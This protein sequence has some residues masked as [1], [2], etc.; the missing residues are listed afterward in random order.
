[1]DANS[2][3]IDQGEQALR[4]R[5]DKNARR[6]E[7]DDPPQSAPPPIRFVITAEAAVIWD[8][9]PEHRIYG[10]FPMKGLALVYGEKKCGKSFWT[11][12]AVMHVA[13]NIPYRGHDVIGGVVVYIA[14]EGQAGLPKRMEAYRR[15]HKHTTSDFYLCTVKPDLMADAPELIENIKRQLGSRRPGIVVVD[16]LNRTL[17]GSESK[18]VD[19][20]RYLAAA[21]SIKDEFGCLVIVVHHCGLEKGR[22]RGH[23]ALSAA[24]DVQIVV[25]RDAAKNVVAEV[26]LAKDGASGEKFT[27]RLDQA[28][29][30]HDKRGNEMTT[31]VIVPIANEESEL[32]KPVKPELSVP[33]QL[34][35]RALANAISER[36]VQNANVWGNQFGVDE[37]TWRTQFYKESSTDKTQEAK[38][39]AFNRARDILVVANIVGTANGWY[40]LARP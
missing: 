34:A 39:K 29:L 7:E 26:E 32:V 24:A 16:T 25:K 38:R 19:V 37:D 11:Y 28:T 5:I 2:I 40:W 10:L 3:L 35:K 6:Y 12:D 31:C 22:P 9:E 36:G 27:S 20:A 21:D 15:H 1:M 17:V 33:N 14:A 18:D 4:D 23:T 13:R 30:G 8:N